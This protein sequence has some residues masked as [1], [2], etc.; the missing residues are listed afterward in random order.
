[1]PVSI[2]FVDGNSK[3]LIIFGKEAFCCQLGM[4]RK[5]QC[6][7][8]LICDELRKSSLATINSRDKFVDLFISLTA[9]DSAMRLK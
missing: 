1:M 9:N 8:K 5:N 2:D 7:W 4:T 3:E 6:I